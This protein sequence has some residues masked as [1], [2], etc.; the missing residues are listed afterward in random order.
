VLDDAVFN[1]DAASDNGGTIDY[2]SPV[3]SWSGPLA[4]GATAT[5]TYS[6]TV[7]DPA[8]GDRR[9]DNAVVTPFGT[10]GNCAEGSTDPACQVNLPAAS[11]TV[12]KTSDAQTA[13]PGDVVTYTVTVTNT[14]KVDYTAEHPASFTDDLRRVLDDAQYN[15][16]VTSG[17]SVDGGTLSWAGALRVGETV[18]VTYS[19]TVDDTVTGDFL[20][21]NVV[22]PSSPGGECVVDGCTTETAVASYTVQK[23][24]DVAQVIRGGTVTY[25][26]TVTNIGQVAYT[27]AVPATFSDDLSAVLDD[28]TY[29]GDATGGAVVEGDRLTWAGALEVGASITVVYS[30]TVNDA[31]TGD[32]VLRNAVLADGPAGSC[33]PA[34]S[35]VTETPVASYRVVKAV[36]RQSGTVGDRV[37]F[38]IT[39]TNTGAADF[40]DEHPASFT[41]DLSSALALGTYNGDASGGAVYQAPVLSWEGPLAVGETAMVTYSVT[42]KRTGEIVNVVVTPPDSGANCAPGSANG[43]CATSTRIVPPGLAVTGAELWAGIGGVAAGFLLLGILLAVRRRRERDEMAV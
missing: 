16:D 38:T 15:G 6:V 31:A 26:V 28:A 25:A 8:T 2:T 29:N 11:F 7:N 22:A 5:I 12:A 39:V 36:N 35:C 32:Q 23:S 27:D 41:D 17:G 4:I 33:D 10:G 37:T 14:G 30:V 1:A 34:S 18:E 19:V 24:S 20:L 9:L 13:M 43:D 21:R 40:T 3:L 42:V